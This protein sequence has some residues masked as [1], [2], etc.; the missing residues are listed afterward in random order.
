[1]AAHGPGAALSSPVGAGAGPLPWGWGQPPPG[2]GP[3]GEAPRRWRGLQLPRRRPGSLGRVGLPRPGAA[4]CF[5]GAEL[6][7]L[8]RLKTD[9]CF[10]ETMGVAGPSWDSARLRRSV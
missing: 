10:P 3:G 7:G 8:W 1:M 2:A 6:R 5:L 9:H 4:P